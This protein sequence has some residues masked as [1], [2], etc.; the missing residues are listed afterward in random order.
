MYK[1]ILSIALCLM[2]VGLSACSNE[3]EDI[4]VLPNES[5][6][7]TA[8]EQTSEINETTKSDQ[9][10]TPQY[11]EAETTLNTQT[12]TTLNDQTEEAQSENTEDTIGEQ[13]EIKTD[14]LSE[15]QALDAIKNYC[16]NHN[17]NLKSMVD[18]GEYNIYWSVTTNDANEIVVLYNSYTAA[19]IRYYIDPLS[20]ET[21]VTE[22]VQ[23]IIDEE[24]RTEE[25]FNVRD[26]LL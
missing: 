19:Q 21:Y 1:K 3:K 6:L 13:S 2:C 8:T 4:T 7:P 14:V 10:K 15:N 5:S 16:F 18:S 24:Q 12:K 17:P 22:W 26:Y 20:G 11:N 25:T 9:P 23:G